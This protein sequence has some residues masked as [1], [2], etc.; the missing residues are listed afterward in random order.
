MDWLVRSADCLILRL[1]TLCRAFFVELHV[2]VSLRWTTAVSPVGRSWFS[3]CSTD[4][5]PIV[6]EHNAHFCVGTA[7]TP[8]RCLTETRGTSPAKPQLFPHSASLITCGELKPSAPIAYYPDIS[9]ICHAFSWMG[10]RC[11]NGMHFT[12]CPPLTTNIWLAWSSHLSTHLT[13]GVAPNI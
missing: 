5:V 2:L 13:V 10:E 8:R 3:G 6:L 4:E 9:G 1:G 11:V 7:A 12:P